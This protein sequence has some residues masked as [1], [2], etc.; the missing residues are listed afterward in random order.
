MTY[1][2]A[3][4]L[5]MNELARDKLV[6]FIGYN[7]RYGHRM[8]GTLS[9][10]SPRKC[11]EMPVAESLMVGL[12][13]GM[14]LEG[15][16]PVIC[17]ERQDFMLVAADQ[18]INHLALLPKVACYN[19]YDEFNFGVLIR[20][21]IGSQDKKFDLGLQHTKDLSFIFERYIRTM[22]FEDHAYTDYAW[23]RPRIITERKDDYERDFIAG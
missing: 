17:F 1:K 21:I 8:Y 16:K 23:Y 15:Y 19:G 10:V 3:I 11:I 2:Q 6:R 14:S 20:A 4:T 12:A 5:E 22:K 9:E 13:M 18:I 7:T